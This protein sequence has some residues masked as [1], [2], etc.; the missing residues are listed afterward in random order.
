MVSSRGYVDYPRRHRH[1]TGPASEGEGYSSS[2]SVREESTSIL[3]NID[4]RRWAHP[5]A[6]SA[7]KIDSIGQEIV[8]G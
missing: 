4:G 1:G 3:G 8:E 6:S 5:R 2:T 7:I